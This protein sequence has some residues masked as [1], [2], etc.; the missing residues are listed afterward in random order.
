M[1]NDICTDSRI[2]ISK[3]LFG[4]RTT[5]VYQPTNSVLD[6]KTA[7]FSP[8]DGERLRNILAAPV[9]D[10][11]K[12][13]GDFR[14]QQV[15]NGNYMAEFCASRDGKFFA[16]QLFHFARISYEPVTSTRIFEGEEADIIKQLF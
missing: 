2:S 14:P 16:I 11:S 12:A 15:V 1:W 3:S 6:A 9:K 7:E 8:A 10:L 4:L 13:I 5:A